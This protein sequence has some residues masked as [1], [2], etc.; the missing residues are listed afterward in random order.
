MKRRKWFPH[1]APVIRPP[2]QT[3]ISSFVLLSAGDGACVA[4]REMP[5]RPAEAKSAG[6]GF[7]KILFN[8]CHV[9]FIASRCVSSPACLVLVKKSW[10][11]MYISGGEKNEARWGHSFLISSWNV[12]KNSFKRSHMC[13]FALQC[14]L[15]KWWEAMVLWTCAGQTDT[16]SLLSRL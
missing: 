13:C 2:G 1:I 16:E 5:G 15:I 9:V 12:L 10:V 4:Q 6:P 11:P 7:S 3:V 8:F 14:K